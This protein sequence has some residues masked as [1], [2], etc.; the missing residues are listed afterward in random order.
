MEE[1]KEKKIYK[2]SSDKIKKYNSDFKER[3]KDEKITCETCYKTY[4]K[5]SSSYHPK[6]KEH[7]MALRIL[8]ELSKN[9]K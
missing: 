8:N 1:V 3:H 9:N 4:N 5:L 7:L 6:S 2:Y